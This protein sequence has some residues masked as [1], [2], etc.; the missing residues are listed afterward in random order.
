MI[1]ELADEAV[2]SGARQHKACE[3]LEIS[4]RTLQRWKDERTPIA[5]QRST[6][7]RPEPK[8]KLT[9]EEKSLILQ[10]VNAPKYA[11]KPPCQIVPAL[12]DQGVYIASESSF[13]RVMRQ[14]DEQHY[15]GRAARPSGQ[16]KASHCATGPNQ[17]WSWD[18][19]YLP[20]PIRG[21]IL[22]LV[23]DHRHFQS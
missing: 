19:S 20:G 5:D 22:L 11:S 18:I 13:Y 2:Q 9:Q 17:V 4:P 14:A 3:I 21:I 6:A 15:R 10:T 7:I 23:P 8:N 1:I 12:A 16:P